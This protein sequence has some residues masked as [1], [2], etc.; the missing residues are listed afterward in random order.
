MTL[1]EKN[2]RSSR[3]V[4]MPMP[5]FPHREITRSTNAAVSSRAGMRLAATV[6]WDPAFTTWTVTYLSNQVVPLFILER[7][8]SAVFLASHLGIRCM[9]IATSILPP[10][11]PSFSRTDTCSEIFLANE[12]A[13][14]DA[15]TRAITFRIHSPQGNT[16]WLRPSLRRSVTILRTAA[17][18]PKAL[19]PSTHA[20]IIILWKSAIP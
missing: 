11:M 14:R 9:S 2:S 20:A 19:I 10:S 12:S 16:R 4:R 3:T 15:S 6:I 13:S 18:Y 7:A 8:R 1:T 17:A 5:P